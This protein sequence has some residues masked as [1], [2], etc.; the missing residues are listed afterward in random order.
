[1][2]A[3]LLALAAFL[4][5]PA[6]AE[7]LPPGLTAGETVTVREAIDGD[8]LRLADGRELRLAGVAAPKPL[9]PRTGA[10]TAPDARLDALAEAARQ[11]LDGWARGQPVDLHF[12]AQRSDRHGRVVAHVVTQ[13]QGWLQA[14]L[15]AQGLA[16]VQ[17]TATTAAGADALLRIEATARAERRGLW[18]HPLFHIRRAEDC[19]RWLDTFQLVEG[20]VAAVRLGRG[21]S[22]I[23]LGAT[24][25][26]LTVLIP[27]KAR[28]ELRA[29]GIELPALVGRSLR[30]RGWI[31]WQ[32]GARM[33]LTHAAALERIDR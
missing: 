30:V 28:S 26:H 9:L 4:A 29:A 24:E 8:T 25:R 33:E 10:S 7:P 32:D 5:A 31:R 15:L 27:A 13:D 21:T 1:M 16:R 23:E 17:M 3:Q 12:P 2:L 6:A 19:G 22:R 14:A 18:A 20:P 11:A